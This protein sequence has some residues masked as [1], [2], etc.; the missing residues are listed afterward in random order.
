MAVVLFRWLSVGFIVRL[1]IFVIFP[2]FKPINIERISWNVL[3]DDSSNG[4]LVLLNLI[5][6]HSNFKFIF[7]NW[8]IVSI[9]FPFLLFLMVLPFIVILVLYFNSMSTFVIGEILFFFYRIFNAPFKKFFCFV[10]F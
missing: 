9:L 8:F 3:A 2:V 7:G 1:V 6:T 10:F 4:I 5:S